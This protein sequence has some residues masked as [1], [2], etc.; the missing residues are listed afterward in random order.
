MSSLNLQKKTFV[1]FGGASGMGLATTLTLLENGAN[2]AFSDINRENLTMRLSELHGDLKS[3]AFIQIADVTDR[4]GVSEFLNAAKAKFGEVDGV[5]NFA[6]TGGRELG[7]EAVWETSDKEFQFIIDLNV[8][9]LF[10]ILSESLRPGF[11]VE[12]ASFVHI[13]SQFSLQGFKNGAVFAASK[14][15][16]LGMVRSAAKETGARV[17]VNCVLPGAIDTPMH[18]ANLARVPGFADALQTPISRPGTAQE[19]ADVTVFLLSDQGSF[20]TGAAW[21]VDGGASAF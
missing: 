10:N 4:E 6:G 13:G 11:L 20:V 7:T 15:A 18:R 9:G 17:R 16:A 14:H 21:S 2:V 5:A 3:R 19:V 8:K 1:I 12:G